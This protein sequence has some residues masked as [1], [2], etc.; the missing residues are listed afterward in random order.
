V[1][2]HGPLDE[3]V[4]ARGVRDVD[5]DRGRRASAARQ[6]V[7]QRCGGGDVDVAD[8]QPGPRTSECLGES[9]A[10]PLGPARDHDDLSR[11]ALEL[12]G[13]IFPTIPGL[14]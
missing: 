5:R 3:L 4:H 13:L 9:P 12:H 2:A 6:F 8:D 11:E 1:Q 10:K 14:L 7:A